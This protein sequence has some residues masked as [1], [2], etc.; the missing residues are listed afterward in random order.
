M[1]QRMVS[2]LM[3]NAIKYTPAGGEVRAT[4]GQSK[5]NQ[6]IQVTLTDTG[7]GIGA[8]DLPLIFNRFFRCDES[9]TLPGTGLGLSLARAVARV[10]G[11]DIQVVSRK[12]EGSTF[13][14][15][16]PA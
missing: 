3:D 5:D 4:V 12:G 16:F 6:A 2:N 9:R 13:T 10:H 1:I 8:E 11:G 15:S 7:T 14:V